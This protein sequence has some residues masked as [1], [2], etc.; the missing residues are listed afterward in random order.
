MQINQVA[1]M[2]QTWGERGGVVL[3]L[4]FGVFLLVFPSRIL[5]VRVYIEMPSKFLDMSILR[6]PS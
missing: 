4:E 5:Q 6:S 2:K 1:I 3:L